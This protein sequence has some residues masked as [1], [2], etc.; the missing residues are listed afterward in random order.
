MAGPSVTRVAAVS[1]SFSHDLAFDLER[2]T[3]I[4]EEAREREV[5]LLVLPH[6]V[7]GGY[8]GDLDPDL[9]DPPDVPPM[10]ALDGPEVAELV[11][12]AGDL[13]VCFGLTEDRGGRPGNTA[14]CVDGSGILGVHRKVHLP[15]GEVRW[16]KPGDGCAAFDTPVGRIGMLVDYD[17]TF[18]EAARSLALDGAELLAFVCAWP[19][20][21]TAQ[22]A[23]VSQDRQSLLFELYDRAR[24]AENQVVVVTSNLTGGQG[25]LRFFGQ[26]KVVQPDGQIV[27]RTGFRPGWA[28]ADIEVGTLVANA[29]RRQHH[30]AERRPRAYLQESGSTVGLPGAGDAAPA[31]SARSAGRAER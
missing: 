20:S 6:G 21:L 5:E 29:R 24:A 18:P 14:V 31:R 19:L 1:G 15:P 22:A 17:K 30:L 11:A 16:Y 3:S 12:A 25:Q 4:I 28:V 26:A 27:A 2:A 23:R 10:V 13:V 8:V 7:L 9:D